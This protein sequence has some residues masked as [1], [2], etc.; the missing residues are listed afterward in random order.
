MN[1]RTFVLCNMYKSSF[2]FS[3]QKFQKINN[4]FAFGY[5]IISYTKK[6]R[7]NPNGTEN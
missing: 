3:L 5:A 6:Q 1:N 2:T 4:L 7:G